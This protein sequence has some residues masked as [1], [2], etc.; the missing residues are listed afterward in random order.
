M[1]SLRAHPHRVA[2]AVLVLL[3]VALSCVL[4]ARAAER[5]AREQEADRLYGEHQERLRPYLEQGISEDDARAALGAGIVAVRP[6][7]VLRYPGPVWSVAFSPDGRAIAAGTSYDDE[8]ATPRLEIRDVRSG[9]VRSRLRPKGNVEAVYF[10]K[11]RRRLV[12]VGDD[13]VTKDPVSR[14]TLQVW[15]WR[16]Q[17]LLS[18]RS[19][20]TEGDPIVLGVSL[21]GSYAL[22]QRDRDVYVWAIGRQ[23]LVRRLLRA[24]PGEPLEYPMAAVFSADGRYVAIWTSLDVE[25]G[26]GGRY[27]LFRTD[28]WQALWLVA[29]P[30]EDPEPDG[31]AFSPDSQLLA[32]VVGYELRLY[33]TR[34]GKPL[35]TLQISAA[36][37]AAF[38]PGGKTLAVS[39]GGEVRTGDLHGTVFGTPALRSEP[40]PQGA[41]RTGDLHGTVFG[42]WWGAAGWVTSLAFS[43]DGRLLAVGDSKGAV[44][45]WQLGP[46]S[47]GPVHRTR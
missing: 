22:L 17:R 43:P 39:F 19:F 15:D 2:I 38:S 16:S 40:L 9:D 41:V 27:G 37:C 29:A 28:S 30:E 4:W 1:L 6:W 26:G 3:S 45:L 35:R 10:L 21:D 24:K 34:T 20:G 23:R 8:R 36:G 32:M 33:A 25:A 31:M 13:E 14:N 12:T 44:R 42:T 47:R 7:R 5:R 46:A 11:D 18:T